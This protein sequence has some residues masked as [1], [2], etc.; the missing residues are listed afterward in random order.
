VSEETVSGLLYETTASAPWLVR[1]ASPRARPPRL[2]DRVREA[3]R[4][5]HYRRRTENA[6]VHWIRRFIFFHG[7][8][9]P[10]EMGATEVTAFLTS[11]AVQ[12]KGRGSAAKTSRIAP[13]R[14]RTCNA[15]SSA[16]SSRP[17]PILRALGAILEDNHDIR[18]IQELL[19]H[20]DVSTTM[21]Y[22]HVLNLG[23][24]GVRSPADRMFL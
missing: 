4:S 13:A 1:E 15:S 18:T 10:A 23:P 11:L 5:R 8:R 16:S 20:R 9:H 22:T 24:A 12:D 14:R 19:G 3:I 6:Y 17:P 2:L 21:I 7:K